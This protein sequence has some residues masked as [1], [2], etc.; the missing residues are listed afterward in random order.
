MHGGHNF[1]SISTR[2]SSPVLLCCNH[3]TV[4]FFFFFIIMYSHQWKLWVCLLLLL[5]QR[6]VD[7]FH[8]L[9]PQRH[10]SASTRGYTQL[11]LH[12]T[13]TTASKNACSTLQ[14]GRR[15][16]ATMT[17][18]ALS[19]ESFLDTSRRNAT[20]EEMQQQTL[21]PSNLEVTLGQRD[22]AIMAPS[23][24]T[25]TAPEQH[26]SQ[27]QLTKP[28]ATADAPP[29]PPSPSSPLI[30]NFE[31]RREFLDALDNNRQTSDELL[32]VKYH[33]H[34]CRIC[35]RCSITYRK[36]AHEYTMKQQQQQQQHQQQ[37]Q[38]QQSHQNTSTQNRIH[39]TRLEASAW[40]ADE[41]KSLGLTKFPFVQIYRQGDCVASF[42]TGPSHLFTRRVRDTLDA[43][44]QRS[45][46]EWEAWT[47]QLFATEIA[48]NHQ[49]RQILRQQL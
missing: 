18:M 20:M 6:I 39:F 32:I 49:A 35:Q 22:V 34:Y 46:V 31:S 30:H 13:A 28:T 41:L 29:P 48:Q 14:R 10:L 37:K 45:D 3:Y 9:L 1:F 43:C 42:S 8:Q 7:G 19:A 2:T 23:T 12:P 27:Q 36:V 38:Q 47:K 26:Q 24:A 44:L 4:Y 15:R 17:N 11:R 40:T 5:Q 25:S 21:V 16:F 33:A